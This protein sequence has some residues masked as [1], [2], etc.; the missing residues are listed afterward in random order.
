MCGA[1]EGRLQ[2]VIG[3]RGELHPC[4]DTRQPSGPGPSPRLTVQRDAVVLFHGLQGVCFPLEVHVGGAQ[5]AAGAVVVHGRLLQR[6]ELS[7]EL[8]AAENA[9]VSRAASLS[10]ARGQAQGVRATLRVLPWEA[11]TQGQ[12]GGRGKCRGWGRRDSAFREHWAREPW[13]T[14]GPNTCTRCG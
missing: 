2:S 11:D 6:P 7:E 10:A 1:D 9:T 12:D 8:L 14:W 4:T 5:A 3:W 13:P